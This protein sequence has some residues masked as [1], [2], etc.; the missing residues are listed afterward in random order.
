MRK[1]LLISLLFLF[2]LA[3][4]NA[5]PQHALS[6]SP[7]F[8]IQS[9]RVLPDANY[10]F[11]RILTDTTLKYR[12]DSLQTA[13]HQIFW[14]KIKVF[15]PY[16]DDENYVV[17]LS[18]PLNYSV[19]FFD[20]TQ[21]KWISNRA[22]VPTATQFRNNGYARVI[23]KKDV[24]STLYF[25][26]DLTNLQ[27]KQFNFKP[28]ILLR[29]ENVLQHEEELMLDRV[30]ISCIVLISLIGYN[31]YLFIY[32]QDKAYLYFMLIQIGGVIFLLS[33]RRYLHMLLPVEFYNI[34]AYSPTSIQ[35]YSLDNFFEHMG[36]LI[37]IW[38]LINFVRIYLSTAKYM[39]K[40]DK[41][42]K[43]LFYGYAIVEFIPS[44]ITISGI[45]NLDH[46]TFVYDNLYIQLMLVAVLTI[47]IIAYRKRIPAAKY[48]LLANILPIALL[49]AACIHSVITNSNPMLPELTIFSQIL[50]FAVAMVA[51]LKM[52]T[53]ELNEKQ[54]EAMR[55][56]HQVKLAAFQ[57]IEIEQ[58][59]T[60]AIS[61]IQ[62]E[63]TKN[64]LLTSQI[65]NNQREIVGN[66]I[67]I[68]QK[69]ALLTELSKQVE[70]I[71]LLHPN[72]KLKGL[73][74]IQSTLRHDD[75]LNEH[76]DK[77][78]LHFEQVHPKFFDDLKIKNATLTQGELRLSAYLHINLSTKEIASL[79]NVLPT[80]V[81]QAKSRLNKKLTEKSSQSE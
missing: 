68:Q 38:G 4:L 42:L 24:I 55:L 56:E 63:K 30:W 45:A 50:T 47:A 13:K 18:L 26:I 74:D 80:S 11:A 57:N 9:Y 78:K 8:S 64:E 53:A 60:R 29:K 62:S 54:I 73:N 37:I 39:P 41:R 33:A 20:P 19:Y 22:G 2:A 17:K 12:E 44:I 69:N 36:I 46:Y 35:Y 79:L 40:W 58:E 14:V 3:K 7:T 70:D 28:S 67:Y 34:T 5:Q 52:L 32:L 48:F 25:R 76:W 81:K 71:D 51:R 66:Q 65:A 77:F 6:K 23:F 10:S 75:Y 31:L 59:N 27:E 61:I 1:L 49:V 16:P 21:H 15:N 43:I 72:L